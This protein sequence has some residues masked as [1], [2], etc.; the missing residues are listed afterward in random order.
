MKPVGIIANPASG[1]DIRRLVAY[2]S[3]SDNQ[4]KVN[5]VRRLLLGLD[6]VGVKEAVFMPDYFGIGQRAADG[7][8][9]SLGVSILEMAVEASQEDS[10]RAA[11]LMQE[12]GVGCIA[13]L[14]GD[15]TTRVVAKGCGEIPI[16]PISTGTNNVFPYMIEGTVA[17]IA[18][19]LVAGG[20][21]DPAKVMKRTPRL[22]VFKNGELTD[23]ALVDVAVYDDLFAGSRAIWDVSRVR[24]IF[25]SRAQAG[26]IGLSSIGACLDGHPSGGLHL[27]LGPG[28]RSVSAPIAPGL[29]RR[30]GIRACHPLRPGVGVRVT[31]QPS[32]LALDGERELSLRK[33]DEVTVSLSNAGPM[34]ID[35][36]RAME[37]GARAGFFTGRT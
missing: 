26:C 13:V 18:A 34:V 2:G 27:Q 37:E 29:I 12:M 32:I 21:V 35:A 28:E 8:K 4:E 19:G 3:V 25:L 24:E 1:K 36:R 9:I 6:G 23:L 14:G 30:V 17:G 11:A 20:F 10:T 5:I 33:E 7:L 31:H 22:E 16:L 15:G